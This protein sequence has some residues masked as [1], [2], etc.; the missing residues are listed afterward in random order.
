MESGM[1]AFWTYMNLAAAYQ[2]FDLTLTAG[3]CSAAGNITQQIDCLVGA[4]ATDIVGSVVDPYCRD[5]C[6]WT[7]VIDG[8]VVPGRT[9]TLARQGKLRPL[10]CAAFVRTCNCVRVEGG[11]GGG[12]VTAHCRCLFCW[13][14]NATWHPNW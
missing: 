9:V 4:S 2:N 14:P 12:H 6:Q 13:V 5:G 7:P 3:G 8:V 1:A 10:T 11:E